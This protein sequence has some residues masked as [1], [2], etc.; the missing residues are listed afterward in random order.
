MYTLL[1]IDKNTNVIYYVKFEIRI[2]TYAN[3]CILYH[4]MVNEKLKDYY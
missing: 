1:V 4:C 3:I 2:F